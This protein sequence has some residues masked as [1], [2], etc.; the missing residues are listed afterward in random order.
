M[1]W[2]LAKRGDLELRMK[3]E[4][5]SGGSHKIKFG[6]HNKGN[7]VVRGV[8]WSIFIPCAHGDFRLD[9]DDGTPEPAIT[10]LENEKWLYFKY[11]GL[12]EKPVFPTRTLLFGMITILA[13][14]IADHP[15]NIHWHFTSEDGPFPEENK[16]G[17]YTL[18]FTNPPI[19]HES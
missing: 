16:S 7:K 3:R 14:T 2:L 5:V 1:R 19:N 18:S 17:I 12:T 9:I 11:A 8:Y 13:E 4:S 10:K 15:F 6:I